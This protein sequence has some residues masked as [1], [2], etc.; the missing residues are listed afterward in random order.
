MSKVTQLF[1]P[2][3]KFTEQDVAEQTGR[4]HIVTGGASGIGFELVKIL[5][6]KNA[7]IYIA[8]RSADKIKSAIKDIQEQCQ[9]SKGRLESLLLDLS[10]LTTIKPAVAEFQ[11]KERRLDVLFHNA[12]VMA[13][14]V[15]SKSAQV[16]YTATPSKPI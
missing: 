5:Y 2:C 11:S 13:T 7:T 15:D 14:P 9:T 6:L 12:G 10:D 1:P 16:G 8:A 4:V 3:P